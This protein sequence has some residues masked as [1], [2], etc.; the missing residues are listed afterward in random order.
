MN[1]PPI[2]QKTV[3]EQ[4]M[5]QIR[6][7]ISTGRFKPGDKF[8]TEVELAESFGLGRSSIREAIKTFQHLGVLETRGP[9]ETYVAKSDNISRE[10]LTWSI[11]LGGNDFY[12][13]MEFRLALEQQGIW[14]LLIYRAEETEFK[15]EIIE[16]LKK[17]IKA[18]EAATAVDDLDARLEADYRF[19]QHLIDA[20]NNRLFTHIYQTLRIFLKE[21]MKLNIRKYGDRIKEPDQHQNLIDIIETGDYL[22]VADAFR[23]HITNVKEVYN[24]GPNGKEAG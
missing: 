4:V 23:Y 11:L 10:A 13:L 7:L 3:V 12:D 15:K 22:R 2:R 1:L 21:E 14:Y 9:R 8:P 18:L 19:H 24:H 16:K 20:C 5:E 6:L 17:E